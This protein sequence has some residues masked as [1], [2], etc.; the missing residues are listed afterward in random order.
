MTEQ[1]KQHITLHLDAHHVSLNVP[2][3]Q[4]HLYRKAAT[5]LKDKYR[6][7]QKKMQTCSAEQLW[8][9]VALDVTVNLCADAH[10]HSLQPVDEKIQELNKK[11]LE[12][13]K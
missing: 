11:I 6:F 5:M 1:H 4:E 8:M 7:Y 10:A 13:L 9:Y 2:I 12:Q 3:A